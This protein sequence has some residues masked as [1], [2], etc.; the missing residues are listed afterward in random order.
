MIEMSVA[1]AVVGAI[2][3]V[4]M[5]VFIGTALKSVRLGCDHKWI[6]RTADVKLTGDYGS[7]VIVL[8]KCSKCPKRN[9]EIHYAGGVESTSPLLAERM[10]V[11]SEGGTKTE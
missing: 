1:W 10:I 8:W 11:K 9:A 6:K 2:C 3:L 7:G 4:F 5:G